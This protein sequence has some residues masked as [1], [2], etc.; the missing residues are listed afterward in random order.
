MLQGNRELYQGFRRDRFCRQ[1]WSLPYPGPLDKDNSCVDGVNFSRGSFP[2]ADKDAMGNVPET[3]Q[4]RFSIQAYQSAEVTPLGAA[5]LPVGA[6]V[7]SLT[8]NDMELVLDRRVSAGT[9]VRVEARNWLMLGEVLYCVPEHSRH[10]ARLRLAHALP[11]LRA[12]SDMN[13]RFLGQTARS[14]QLAL[15][16]ESEGYS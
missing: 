15:A 9:A 12:L 14:Q 7:L 1:Y 3:A 6:N 4:E 8:G 11:G 2:R 16:R 13:R 5:C 10:K